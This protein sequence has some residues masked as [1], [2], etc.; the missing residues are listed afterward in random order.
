M[1]ELGLEITKDLALQVVTLQKEHKRLRN[2]WYS[3]QNG[4]DGSAYPLFF[5]TEAEAERDQAIH[6]GELPDEDG[7]FAQE[8]W[9]ESCYGKVDFPEED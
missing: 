4:G 6:N 2:T 7:E 8:G 3:I 1:S 9:A 5:R